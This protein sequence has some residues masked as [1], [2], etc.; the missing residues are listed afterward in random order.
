[1]LFIPMKQWAQQPAQ[2]KVSEFSVS[3]INTIEDRVFLVHSILD[4]GYYCYR[5]PDVPN[6]I[7][8]YVASDA[9]DELSDFDFYFDNVL[10]EQLNEFH[11]LSKAMRGELF[12]QWR[13]GLDD[14]IFKLIYEDFTKGVRS[15]NPTCETALPFCTNNGLYNFPAGVNAGSPCTTLF[16]IEMCSDP[17]YCTG[18]HQGQDNCLSTAPNP[19][20]YFMRIADPGNLN[21]YMYSTP[22]EDIDFD[23]WGPFESMDNA[24]DQLSCSTMVDCSYDPAA[25]EHCHINN[26]QT[27]QYYILLITN[28]SNATCNVNF[29]NIGTGSTDCSILAPLVNND[30]P[31]CVGETINLTAVGENGATYSWTGPN[32]FTSSQQNPTITNCTLDNAGDYTCTITIGNEHNQGGTTIVVIPQ[33]TATFETT[34]V[35]LGEETQFTS[36]GVTDPSV[37]AITDFSWDFGDGATG[38]GMT[39]THTYTTAGTYQV[40]H[41]V[42]TSSQC[43]DEITQTV[44]VNAMPV[45]TATANPSTV[46]YGGNSTI[47]GD[48]GVSGSFS[49]HWEPA[50]MVTNPDSQTTQTVPLTETQVYTLTV[51]NNDGGCTSTTT[52]TV[53][54]EGSNLTASATADR[55]ELCE[56]ET[57]IIHAIPANGTGNYTY[58]WN[59]DES[60]SD[61]LTQNPVITPGLGS[62]TYTCVISDGIVDQTVSVTVNVYPVSETN[63]TATICQGESYPFLGLHLYEGGLYTQ[64]LATAHNCDSVVNLELTVNPV[65]ESEFTVPEEEACD[66]YFWDPQGHIITYTD[67]EDEYYTMSGHYHRTYMNEY[68]C[69]SLVTMTV[70]LEY[71]PDPTEIMPLDPDNITPHWVVT[72]SEFQINTYDFTFWDHNPICHW[73]SIVWHIDTPNISWLLEPDST[74]HPAGKNVKL[75]VLERIEDTIWFHANVYNRCAPEGKTK[76]YWV[77]C[78]FYDVDEAMGSEANFSVMPNPNNGLMTLNFEHLTGKVNVKVYD[79]RGALIDNFETFNDYESCSMTYD[80]GNHADGIY[81][82]VATGKEGTIAKKVVI[83]R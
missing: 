78:S 25:T 81:H 64:T 32:G 57:T 62:H 23:C 46:I 76:S 34:P 50:D 13:R 67:H 19:A 39:V 51:T 42:T 59:P 45:P 48:A 68:G 70:R 49:Y 8:V 22:S 74:T 6:T 31:Y 80:M 16:G 43:I 72:A 53:Y 12:V 55:Y 63:L 73:D 3:H 27:G 44:V 37:Q 1:M 14:E 52:V 7:D 17:Y 54:M 77:V 15:D 60:L 18:S 66:Q 21:I 11:Y 75:Y 28:F 69:D 9:S 30:G 41:T 65:Y 82:F 4:K 58:T 33:P 2:I 20:F 47:T 61:T 56:G 5:N 24:C 83:Q 79:M 26:A 36:T 10:Y 35:C 38:N 71:T 40:T 29:E